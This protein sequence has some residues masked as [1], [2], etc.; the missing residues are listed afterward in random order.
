MERRGDIPN[1]HAFPAL[2]F[3]CFEVIGRQV[4]SRLLHDVVLNGEKVC[5]CRSRF[6][7]CADNVLGVLDL[8]REGVDCAWLILHS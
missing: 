4:C 1:S 7:C 5:G 6:Q 3:N 8:G 2:G